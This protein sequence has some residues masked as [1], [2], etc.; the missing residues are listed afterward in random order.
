MSLV[1]IMLVEFMKWIIVYCFFAE[2]F[3]NSAF[4]SKYS[5][6]PIGGNHLIGLRLKKG[7]SGT[8]TWM[9]I[10]ANI[11]VNRKQSIYIQQFTDVFHL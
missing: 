7:Q 3:F 8:Q 1:F 6:E 11:M 2:F 10:A 9:A 4:N 5:F